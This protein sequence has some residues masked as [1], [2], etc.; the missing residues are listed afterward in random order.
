VSLTLLQ[1]GKA[2]RET[3]YRVPRF[4]EGNRRF[5]QSAIQVRFGD[6]SLWLGLGDRA[7]LRV[8]DGSHVEMSYLSKRVNL[9]FSLKLDQF[10]IDY[11][12]GTRDPASYWSRVRV[13]D[14]NEP[15]VISMNQPLKYAGYTFYQSSYENGFP[16]PT[17]SIFSVNQDPGRTLKYFGSILLVLGICVLFYQKSKTKRKNQS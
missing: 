14:Q 1:T 4:L 13:S 17:V 6:E 12:P 11:H 5:Y 7:T 10:Q 16:R 8:Q 15:V 9:P 2:F 3:S